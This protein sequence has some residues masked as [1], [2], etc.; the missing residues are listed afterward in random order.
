[1]ADSRIGV[2][3]LTY[4]CGHRLDPV[5][6]RLLELDVPIVAV[7][8]ASSDSTRDVL[9]R[10]RVPTVALPRNIGAA[11]RNVGARRLGADYG[12]EYVAFCDDDGWYEPEG[13]EIAAGLLDRYPRLA[14]VNARIVVG[15]ERTLDPISAEMER[16]PLPEPMG[17]P[18]HVL[19][20]FMAGAAIVRLSAYLDVGGYDPEFFM[21]GEEDTLAV[22]LVRAGWQMRYLPE[23]V[24]V[25]QPSL[26]NASSLRASGFRNA[27]WTVWLHRRFPSV[28]VRTAQLLKD[29]PKSADWL[30]GLTMALQGLPWI[31]RRRRPIGRELDEQYRLLE[32]RRYPRQH[33]PTAVSRNGSD[34][35]AESSIGRTGTGP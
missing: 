15:D 25:H 17:I 28:L 35:P 3:L 26:A 5:L 21:G 1:M 18:G 6:D 16:S 34:R 14:L 20:G 11:A 33:V 23:V 8:N 13:L 27:L 22:K 10:R 4:N 7:D 24:V 2:V 9:F 32:R 12:V 31:L 29:E 19:L 30:R